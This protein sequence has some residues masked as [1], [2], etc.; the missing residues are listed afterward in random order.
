MRFQR[1]KER[2]GFQKSLAIYYGIPFRRRRMRRFYAPFVSPGELCFDIGSHVGNRVRSFLDLGAKVIAVEPQPRFVD[3]L[4]RRYGSNPDV[5]ILA[6]GVG[7]RN[8]K[9]RLHISSLQPTLSTFSDAWIK[10]VTQYEHFKNIQWDEGIEQE[11]STLDDLIQQFGQPDFCKIDVE[12]YE[13]EVLKGLTQ[14]VPKLSFEFIPADIQ[15][16]LLCIDRL[17]ELGGYR[18]NWSMVESLTLASND[19]LTP[20]DMKKTLKAMP[21]LGP[22]GDVYGILK[23]DL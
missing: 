22:S 14:P 1:L 6:K 23:D 10:E 9:K 12:G 4:R 19:W 13:L 11:I 16:A 21:R 17:T 18:Y 15:N 20:G 2:L 3:Y 8:S 7:A 5:T